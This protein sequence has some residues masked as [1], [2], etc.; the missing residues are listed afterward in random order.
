MEGIQQQFLYKELTELASKKIK[1]FSV[2]KVGRDYD[3]DSF[4]VEQYLEILKWC[5]KEMG[6]NAESLHSLQR[7]IGGVMPPA[8]LV[9]IGSSNTK[10]DTN[11]L[12]EVVEACP[13]GPILDNIKEHYKKYGTKDKQWGQ[14]YRL[15]EFLETLKKE[16][17]KSIEVKF[18]PKF[19]TGEQ[20]KDIAELFVFPYHEYNTINID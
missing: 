15:P 3:G 18:G 14:E 4:F 2:T 6:I 11:T 19:Y 10:K 7:H 16:G 5:L 20:L 8:R 17:K 13:E 12:I 9:I 1:E